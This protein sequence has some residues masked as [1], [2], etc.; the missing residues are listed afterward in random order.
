MPA[1]RRSWASRRA[2]M[3]ATILARIGVP[4]DE[5]VMVGD[6]LLTDVGLARTAGMTSGL[7]LTGATTSADVA[8]AA[9]PPDLILRAPDR[10]HPRRR[11]A[12]ARARWRP[13]R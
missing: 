11:P 12:G 5:A 2:H 8:A 9:L 1:R 4:A 13:D 6:R 10:S 7:V 3:A